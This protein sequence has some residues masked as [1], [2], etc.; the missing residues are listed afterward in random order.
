[1]TVI[2]KKDEKI[3][4]TAAALGGIINFYFGGWARLV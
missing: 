2:T 3:A 4:A 1:M